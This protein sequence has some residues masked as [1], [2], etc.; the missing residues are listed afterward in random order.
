MRNKICPKCSYSSLNEDFSYC[1]QCG[2]VIDGTKS[3]SQ[4]LNKNKK[5]KDLK[6]D[7]KQAKKNKA[8]LFIVIGFAIVFLGMNFIVDSPNRRPCDPSYDFCSQYTPLFLVL[9]GTFLIIV[10]IYYA[11]L[12]WNDP[13]H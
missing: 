12:G 5:S 3:K 8:S 9:G 7:G 10:G 1:P 2:S 13:T 4:G 6:Q 11:I